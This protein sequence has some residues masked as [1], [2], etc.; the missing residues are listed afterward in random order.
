[1]RKKVI[2]KESDKATL[3]RGAA[4]IAVPRMKMSAQEKNGDRSVPK[5]SVQN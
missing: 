5:G 1:M 3:A 4:E 2:R